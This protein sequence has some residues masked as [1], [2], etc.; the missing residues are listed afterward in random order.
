M[1][2]EQLAGKEVQSSA[3]IY[4]FAVVACE[5]LTGRHPF[6][7]GLEALPRHW[8]RAIRKAM[9]VEPSKRF[10]TPSALLEAVQSSKHRGRRTA[11]AAAASLCIA[12]ALSAAGINLFRSR[13]ATVA[14]LPFEV[15]QGD[16][17]L[18]Y[19]GDGISE[20]LINSMTRQPHLRV[21]AKGSA[22][23][24]RG[25]NADLKNAGK[26][27]G[28]QYLVVGS[29]RRQ[30]EHVRIA[31]AL[32]DPLSSFQIWASTFDRPENEI[33]EVHEMMATEIASHIDGRSN[34]PHA[35]P[36]VQTINPEAHDLY[37]RGLFHVNHRTRDETLAALD[38][39][40][41]AIQKA[42]DYAPL[43]TA[44]ADC[45]SVLGDRFKSPLEVSGL[46]HA[47]IEQ[48]LRL[49]PDLAEAHAS[50]GFWANLYG[51]D[52]KLAET[53]FL[54]AISL[55]PGYAPAHQWYSTLLY[56][57]R[58][59]EEAAREARRA[60][61][62]D[63]VSAAV[64]LNYGNLFYYSRDFKSL[65]NQ[66][67]RLQE[68]D[69]SLPFAIHHKALALAYLGRG[70]EAIATMAKLNPMQDNDG[71]PVRIWAEILA[72]AGDQ[73]RAREGLDR[74]LQLHQQNAVLASFPAMIY[75]LLGDAG[76][77]CDWLEK[78]ER[79]HDTNL[80]VLDVAPP[81]DSL[82]GNPRF[83]A[84]RAR[85]FQERLKGTTATY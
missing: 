40:H 64:N 63:P 35:I 39:F 72:V 75:A 68:M 81:F 71:L 60:L 30:S 18:Q 54:K 5:L 83:Q 42:P 62:L 46:A 13:E 14:V 25:A 56:K 61:E 17:E 76:K 41:Q 44:L 3:D 79:E 19:L 24:F 4:S 29:V 49:N 33:L 53:S 23:R 69:P 82:R 85:V 12:A 73:T 28:V 31:I 59:F 65:L 47:A 32:V 84:V 2:P 66:S 58:R 9:D 7:G 11:L 67:A 27:L 26:Q 1:P 21:I 15:G 77:A 48:A 43:Y 16:A 8:R 80:T 45:Y 70:P 38:L 20:E 78:A 37:L 51:W 10:A 74:L 34:R 57:T 6:D 55:S 36:Q 22:F 52:N 50:L